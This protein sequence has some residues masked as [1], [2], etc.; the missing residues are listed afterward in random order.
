MSTNEL[1]YIYK[2]RKQY[3][4]ELKHNIIKMDLMTEKGREMILAGIEYEL[5]HIQTKI[6]NLMW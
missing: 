3:L 4:L 5:G 1:Y 6:D 2:A